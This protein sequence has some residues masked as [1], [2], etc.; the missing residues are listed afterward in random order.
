[1]EHLGRK[2]GAQELL[3]S[4]RLQFCRFINYSYDLIFRRVM[5]F[6]AGGGCGEPGGARATKSSRRNAWGSQ[7]YAELITRAIESTPEG[8]LT[9]SQIYDW[10]VRYVPYF[11]DKGDSNSSAGWKNSIRHNLSL[12]NRFVRVQNEGTGK[13]SW[14]MLNPE[15]GR[16]GKAP[17]RR[18]LDAQGGA[19]YS[20]TKGRGPG[21][22]GAGGAGPGPQRSP[23]HGSPAGGTV[24]EGRGVGFDS[25]IERLHPPTGC[26]APLPGRPDRE[27]QEPVERL[28][29]CAAS[30]PF[31]PSPAHARS[32][33]S[34]GLP[35]LADLAAC[36]GVEDGFTQPPR[37]EHPPFPFTAPASKGQE[38]YYG[39]VYGQARLEGVLHH[40]PMQN[41]HPDFRGAAGPCSTSGALQELLGRGRARYRADNLGGE[42]PALTEPVCSSLQPLS[43]NRSQSRAP[44]PLGRGPGLSPDDVRGVRH[45][46]GRPGEVPPSA[47]PPDPGAM[48]GAMLGAVQDSSHLASAPQ[49]RPPL[50]PG[51]HPWGVIDQCGTGPVHQCQGPTVDYANRPL[52]PDRDPHHG[53]LNCSADSVLLG[54][55]VDLHRADVSY[56]CA[57]SQVEQC[58]LQDRGSQGWVPS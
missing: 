45:V 53:G 14:W 8:R 34:E 26:S 12:H 31:Y 46:Y 10:M 42:R 50:F 7:S 54:D 56:D 30:P 52:C 32:P 3:A 16:M 24:A 21:A 36:V 1:M 18:A 37:A 51:G 43:Q 23:E 11:R 25:W 27:L 57:V 13:S 5:V 2:E 48:L 33:A 20:K 49:A 41:R 35:Q 55:F 47:P 19:P 28:R 44:L 15:G 38:S 29:S 6:A 40:S 58:P 39:S 4:F 17:R 22:S 9:L